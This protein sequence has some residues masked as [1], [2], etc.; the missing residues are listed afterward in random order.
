MANPSSSDPLRQAEESIERLRGGGIGE[1]RAHV[2][3]GADAGAEALALAKLFK[4]AV[5]TAQ[6]E[7]GLDAFCR[8]L[9]FNPEHEHGREKFR[10]FARLAEALNQFDE[11]S[12]ATLLERQ[13]ERELQQGSKR[14]VLPEGED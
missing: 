12:V 6:W 11:R 14:Q 10:S 4:T 7:L 8:L 2:G 1:P 5:A 9:G 13:A 3:R